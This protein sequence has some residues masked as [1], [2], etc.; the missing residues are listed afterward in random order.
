MAVRLR[1]RRMGKKKQP[2]YRIVAIDSRVARDGKYLENLG[3]YNPIKN[4]HELTVH[5][6]RA[7]YWLQNGA[8]PSDTVRSLFRK[9]G[10]LLRWDLMKR[11]KSEAEIE[12][13]IKKWDAQQEE[14]SRRL[15]AARIQAKKKEEVAKEES[16]EA[17]VDAEV[18][19][20]ETAPEHDQGETAEIATS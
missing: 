2:F 19:Q 13:E 10:V 16:K 18:Q 15:E 3:N 8:Q 11:G 6:D 7:L 20:L 12:S 4:P 14:R 9:K 17:S 1:L 5:V